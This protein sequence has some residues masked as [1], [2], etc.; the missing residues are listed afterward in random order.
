MDDQPIEVRFCH[1]ESELARHMLRNMFRSQG[2]IWALIGVL[3]ALAAALLVLLSLIEAPSARRMSNLVLGVA[4]LAALVLALTAAVAR[5]NARRQLTTSKE[6]S[7]ELRYRFHKQTYEY[8]SEFAAAQVR[9]A[10]LHSAIERDDAFVLF[11]SKAHF[12]LLPKR[13][14]S[15]DG[16]L[17]RFRRLLEE[18]LGGKAQLRSSGSGFR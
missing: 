4:A 10:A 16:A 18:V 13:G 15:N 3:F 11:P 5:L 2:W 14:F 8:K 1:R 12:V 6:L 9:W 17:H 7:G